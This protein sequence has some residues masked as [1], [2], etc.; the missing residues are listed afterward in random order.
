MKNRLFISLII[1]IALFSIIFVDGCGGGTDNIITSP[2][3]SNQNPNTGAYIHITVTWPQ[4]GSVGKC[5][6]SSGKEESTITASM[7]AD[8][9]QIIVK[10]RQAIDPNDPDAPPDDPNSY[11]K[12][13][14]AEILAPQ[15]KVTI[16]PLPA[17]KVKVRAETYDRYGPL[18]PEQAISIVE[19]EFQLYVLSENEIA[20]PL[21]DYDLTLTADPNTIVLGGSTVSGS[22]LISN[23]V[24]LPTPTPGRTAIKNNLTPMNPCVAVVTPEGS[25]LPTDTPTP[26]PTPIRVSSD[27]TATLMIK[28]PTPTDNTGSTSVPTPK[29]IANKQITFTLIKGNDEYTTLSSE[30]SEESSDET[31]ESDTV[32]G[33]TNSKGTCT[34]KL[35]SGTT[36]DKVIKASFMADLNDPNSVYSDQC[37]ITVITPTPTPIRTPSTV[38]MNVAGNWKDS[39]N[40]AGYTITQS[41]TYQ[42]ELTFTCIDPG[43]PTST[44]APTTTPPLINPTPTLKPLPSEGSWNGYIE[45][46][47]ISMWPP[48]H[49]PMI[50][51][52][53]KI[54]GEQYIFWIGGYSNR[55]YSEWV[56]K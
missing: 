36:G 16:G 19:K 39:G 4:N 56:M 18:L 8:T 2:S 6:M 30:S 34:I 51:T 41:G 17:I 31:I 43:S 45:D 10:V 25:P 3:I 50:G 13:G 32:T 42:E 24:A 48:Y 47:R 33:T 14:Y 5:I 26:T 40:E 12:N 54:S 35:L 29:F 37:I 53:K 46:N 52:V 44:P 7:P 11:L 1:L 15:D 38:P 49:E 55:H 9:K 21:G 28:Y 23:I 20:M 22:N 27:I